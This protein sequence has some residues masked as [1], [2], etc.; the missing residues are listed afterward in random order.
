MAVGG[1]SVF[2]VSALARNP[3]AP[4]TRLYSTRLTRGG[5]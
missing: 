5:G 2:D 4:T 3:L 1:H